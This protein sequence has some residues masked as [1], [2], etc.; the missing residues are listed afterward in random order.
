M[1]KIRNGILSGISAAVLLQPLAVTVTQTQLSGKSP[2]SIISNIW[3]S[4]G[5]RGFYRASRYNF[6]IPPLFYGTYLPIYDYLNKDIL[7]KYFENTPNR[8]LNALAAGLS[9]FATSF[10]INPIYVVKI[11]TQNKLILN[12]NN[13]FRSIYRREG[14]RSFY[15]GYGISLFKGSELVF[16]MPMMEYLKEYV[17]IPVASFISRLAAVTLTYP[18]E[19]LR[20]RIRNELKPA[21]QIIREI[22]NGKNWYKGY[23]I[24]ALKSSLKA[25][26]VFSLYEIL[27]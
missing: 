20:L 14:L 3:K 25:M 19:V 17:P 15:R 26:I 7:P 27:K 9:Y 2:T 5:I 11:R 12:S 4:Q 6:I 8:V 13:T 1:E 24:Y 16:Q 23:S 21:T 22:H 18:L 10:A